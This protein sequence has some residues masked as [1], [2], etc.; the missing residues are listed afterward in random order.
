MKKMKKQQL[1]KR[2]FETISETSPSES[3]QYNPVNQTWSHR[4]SAVMCP[5]KN[6][7]EE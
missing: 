2:L 7:Q 5:V 3:G 6:N 4:K 1:L